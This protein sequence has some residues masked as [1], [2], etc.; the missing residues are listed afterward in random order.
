MIQDIEPHEF[1]NEYVPS[2][3]QTGDYLLDFNEQGILIRENEDGTLEVPEYQGEKEVQFLFTLD[4][5]KYFLAKKVKT[6][7]SYQRMT[8]REV[9]GRR[10]KEVVFAIMTGYHLFRWYEEHRFCG[11]CGERL[12]HSKTERML[13]CPSCGQM[14]Y[15]TIAP[16]IIV[17]VIHEDKILVTQYAGRNYK[18]DALIA[19]FTEIGETLEQT[20]KREVMEEVGLSVKNIVYYKNQPWGM[21]CNLLVGF[22]AELEGDEQICLDTS[23]LSVGKWVRRLDMEVVQEDFSLTR[24]MMNVFAIHGRKALKPD[25]IDRYREDYR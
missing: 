21:A 3:P 20:V 14:H 23:E 22:F 15:P 4:E 25:E 9:R 7:S 13:Y 17:G 10:P 19:G 8:L 11:G 12:C 6:D 1:H 18:K 24:E 5:K 16:A 2:E